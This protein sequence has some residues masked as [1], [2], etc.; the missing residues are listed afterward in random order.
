VTPRDGSRDRIGGIGILAKSPHGASI[1]LR[2]SSLRRIAARPAASISKIPRSSKRRLSPLAILQFFVLDAEGGTRLGFCDKHAG[3]LARTQHAPRI[4]T[5]LTLIPGWGDL[6]ASGIRKDLYHGVGPQAPAF[7]HRPAGPT[8]RLIHDR[9]F[10]QPG[11]A[12]S[13]RIAKAKTIG[14]NTRNVI[15]MEN[16]NGA[17]ALSWPPAVLCTAAIQRPVR[18][19]KNSS[20]DERNH[21]ASDQPERERENDCRR[22]PARTETIRGPS[23]HE[24]D[25]GRSSAHQVYR[26]R[27]D[28]PT[29]SQRGSAERSTKE[30]GGCVPPRKARRECRAV[31]TLLADPWLL[32]RDVHTVGGQVESQPA[33][34]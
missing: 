16:A 21:E 34:L 9:D 3:T 18:N 6:H 11:L 30:R 26:G 32:E 12:L 8:V 17:R 4:G 20:P 14:P 27:P 1:A 19:R 23:S 24:T 25:V 28:A 22:N 29:R 10:G 33:R 5:Q 13:A 2:S 15:S 31:G 7:P